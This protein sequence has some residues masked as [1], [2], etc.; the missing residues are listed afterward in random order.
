MWNQAQQYRLE[1]LGTQKV[2]QQDSKFEVSTWQLSE[3]VFPPHKRMNEQKKERNR[4]KRMCFMYVIIKRK[5]RIYMENHVIYFKYM[6]QK[7]VCLC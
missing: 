5:C 7:R 4:V 1:S 3:T 2:R 6:Q